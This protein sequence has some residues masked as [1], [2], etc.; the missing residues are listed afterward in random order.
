M[1]LTIQFW[2]LLLLIPIFSCHSPEPKFP[3]TPSISFQKIQRYKIFDQY[4][5]TYVDSISVSLHFK[6]GDGDLGLSEQDIT[7][8]YEPY[9]FFKNASGDTL[10]IGD[11]D[12]LPPYNDCHYSIGEFSSQHPGQDTAYI[13]FNINYFNYFTELWIKTPAG[14]FEKVDFSNICPPPLD[15]RYPML[16]PANY[17]GPIQGT[18]T[19]IINDPG[20]RNYVNGKTG[21]FKIYIKDRALNQSNEIETSEITF[22]Y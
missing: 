16:N 11:N 15:G 14:T 5:Q 12:T 21:K 2:C 10:L 8:P 19:L 18:L 4:T 7:P 1:R 9:L 22:S 6:D 17:V 3:K 20:L 13:Q